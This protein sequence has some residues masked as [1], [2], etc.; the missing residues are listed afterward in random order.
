MWHNKVYPGL[1]SFHRFS[2][3]SRQSHK[4]ILNQLFLQCPVRN[5]RTF[6]KW[7]NPV[8]CPLH[9]LGKSTLKQ[10][11]TS[12]CTLVFFSLI[13]KHYSGV[14]T[15]LRF[16]Y[17]LRLPLSFLIW[18][19]VSLVYTFPLS[20]PSLWTSDLHSAPRLWIVSPGYRGRGCTTKKKANSFRKACVLTSAR[21][22]SKQ[23]S[24]EQKRK[25]STFLSLR[26]LD[27][28]LFDLWR[29]VRT[30]SWQQRLK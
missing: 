27:L 13:I 18:P 6:M 23:P 7:L 15:L 19:L 14:H 12:V 1:D 2:L 22:L 24:G 10:S 25:E 28:A 5:R 4:S 11:W 17:C 8:F 26:L 30:C 9:F 20:K 16:S 21:P 29:T 3:N